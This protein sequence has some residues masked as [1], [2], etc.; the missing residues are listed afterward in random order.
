MYTQRSNQDVDH[1]FA[2][3]Q[4]VCV[5]VCV[6]KVTSFGIVLELEMSDDQGSRPW[7]VRISCDH[8]AAA[9]C[10]AWEL[11]VGDLGELL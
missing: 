10:E 4:N 9:V 8:S 3:L 5:C 6:S 11:L 7:V 2:F 1:N